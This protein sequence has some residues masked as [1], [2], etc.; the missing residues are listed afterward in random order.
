VRIFRK[1]KREQARFFIR[2]F[3]VFSRSREKKRKTPSH[4]KMRQRF[5]SKKIDEKLIGG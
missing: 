4:E 5:I 1:K 2:D 3:S